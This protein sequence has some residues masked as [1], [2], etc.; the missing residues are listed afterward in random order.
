MK[1]KVDPFF[2]PSFFNIYDLASSMIF[3]DS[4]AFLYNALGLKKHSL[5]EIYACKDLSLIFVVAALSKFNIHVII[6]YNFAL[7]KRIKKFVERYF[8]MLKKLLDLSR[9][10]C[11]NK[12]R[13]FKR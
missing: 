1:I 3:F 6:A 7:F 11:Y 2:P 12:I 10:A 5:A 13:N 4:I 9:C 8:C